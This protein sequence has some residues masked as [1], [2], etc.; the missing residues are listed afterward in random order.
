MQTATTGTTKTP[1]KRPG[2]GTVKSVVSSRSS[3]LFPAPVRKIT[4]GDAP[5]P[6]AA[7][8]KWFKGKGPGSEEND[9]K[10]LESLQERW[11]T[12]QKR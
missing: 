4:A 3:L 5:E 12:F 1:S 10:K 2:W 6:L 7:I 11:E 9:L 8:A